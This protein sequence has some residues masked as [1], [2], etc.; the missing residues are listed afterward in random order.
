[1]NT[2]E[3]NEL[4]RQIS[5]SLGSGLVSHV[6][7]SDACPKI[8]LN[9]GGYLYLRA[10]YPGNK[11]EVNGNFHLPVLKPNGESRNEYFGDRWG[12]NGVKIVNPSIS[13]NADKGAPKCAAD[14]IR[15]FLPAYAENYKLAVERRDAE[16]TH[17]ALSNGVKAAIE[18]AVG[19]RT[20]NRDGNDFSL[21]VNRGD[22]AGALHLKFRV[23][24][25]T[26]E[27]AVNT[28]LPADKV[29]RVIEFL[30]T[31]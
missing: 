27:V 13:F 17:V 14:I 19:D 30:K 29:L 20:H 26:A 24:G 12:S 23:S 11:V 22:E 15:R 18:Q 7:A 5:L 1:M 3:L 28:Y 31:L 6:E 10:G 25:E 2:N 21:T 16:A 9:A 8:H 4:A